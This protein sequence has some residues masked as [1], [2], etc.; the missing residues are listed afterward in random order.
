MNPN[1]SLLDRISRKI[2]AGEINLPPA[3]RITEQLQEITHDPNFDLGKVVDLI[4]NDPVLTGE[5]LRIANSSFYGGLTEIKT[6]KEAVVR[7]G[8]PEVV[9]LAILITEKSLYKVES[10][11]LASF[12][13]PLWMH[14]QATALGAKWLTSKLG[15]AD[16]ENQA[17]IGGLLHD[18]GSLLMVRIMDEIFQDDAQAANLSEVLISEIIETAHTTE[19]HKLAVQWGLPQQY[20][21]IIKDHHSGNLSES[22]T[23]INLVCLVDKACN[24]LGIGLEND[25]SL[26]LS[27]TEEAFTLGAK[28]LDLAQ[29]S[30]LLEDEMQLV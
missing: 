24:Q 12:L 7:L 2:D 14:A 18:V 27:A 26:V 11:I 16:L 17:F 28:D 23:L 19:G 5:I 25:S 1:S 30:I 20:C 8:P 13:E 3:N 9:R 10:P 29:L 21:D 6:V 15:Y 22:G 4:V